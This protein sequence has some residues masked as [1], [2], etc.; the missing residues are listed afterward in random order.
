MGRERERY[1]R[2]REAGRRV[3]ERMTMWAPHVS[4]PYCFFNDKWV[5]HIYF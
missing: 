5:P 2:R 4:G 1:I 3:G